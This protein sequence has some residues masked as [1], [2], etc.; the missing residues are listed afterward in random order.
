MKFYWNG[1]NTK[2]NR[3]LF[4]GVVMLLCWVW[5]GNVQIVASLGLPG[6]NA[7]RRFAGFAG[8]RFARPG[9]GHISGLLAGGAL[10]QNTQNQNIRSSTAAINGG[11]PSL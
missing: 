6:D 4:G 2:A 1:G 7:N 11:L 9:G 3:M 10:A 5:W 8:A